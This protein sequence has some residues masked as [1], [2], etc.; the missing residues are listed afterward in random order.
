MAVHRAILRRFH[1]R[2]GK[3]LGPGP[4]RPEQPPSGPIVGPHLGGGAVA[5]HAEAA[6]AGLS[7][8]S[9][10]ASSSS[11]TRAAIPS[12]CSEAL[13]NEEQT[14][15]AVDVTDLEVDHLADP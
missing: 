9:S 14:T 12:V 4:L 13:S 6:Q 3:A 11:R 1:L 10:A 5:L 2:P 15:V 8:S 7:Y